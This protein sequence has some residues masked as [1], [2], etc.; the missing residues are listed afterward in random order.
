MRILLVDDEPHI[1]HLL[2]RI[3]TR[4]GHEVAEAGSAG[5]ALALLRTAAF[6][7]LITDI[8]MPGLDGLALVRRAKAIQPEIKPIVITGHA[9]DYTLQDVLAAGAA[10]L[11]LKPLRA[12][13]LRARLKLADDQRR[14]EAQIRTEKRALQASS[15]QMI[16]GLQRELDEARQVVARLS[17][18]LVRGDEPI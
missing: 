2:G 3:C 1:R 15:S 9:G 14:A 16:D 4:E 6:D 13:E 8:V 17:A 10:D 12:A 18:V 11:I 5:E 7:M